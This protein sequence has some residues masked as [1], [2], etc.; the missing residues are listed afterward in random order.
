VRVPSAAT[1]TYAEEDAAEEEE[2]PDPLLPEPVL[3]LPLPAAAL[4]PLRETEVE[5][6]RI[7]QEVEGTTKVRFLNT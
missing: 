2:D 3:L 1:E 4:L 5:M 6:R 7:E